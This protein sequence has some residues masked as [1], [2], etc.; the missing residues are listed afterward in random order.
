MTPAFYVVGSVVSIQVGQACGKELFGAV[1]AF[2]VVTLRLVLAAAVLVLVRRPRLPSSRRELCL[3]L[4]LGTAVAGMNVI[5]LALERL[6]MGVAV[7][8]QFLGPLV[9][10][11]LGSRRALDVLWAGLA[12]CGV[13]LFVDPLGSG[14]A[15]PVT[16]LIFALVSGASMAA[17]VVLNKRAGARSPDGSQLAYAVVWAALLSLPTGLAHA[18]PQL[19]RPSVLLAGLGVAVLSA[20]LPYSLDMAALRRLPSRVVAVLECLEPVVAGIAAAVI[21]GE[22][23]DRSQWVAMSCVVVSSLGA[24]LTPRR[25][26]VRTVKTREQGRD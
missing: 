1:G 16:G 2:G 9:L 14:S 4:A 8:V 26:R 17:Y 12:W 3:V 6:E 24:V 25:G 20:V 21:L 15:V 11:L 5:Y 7:S 13:W 22:I 18:G 19:L 10:A 23:L